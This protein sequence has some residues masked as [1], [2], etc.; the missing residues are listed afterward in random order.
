MA[1][2]STTATV[3]SKNVPP[4]SEA[5][6]SEASAT[7]DASPSSDAASTITADEKR[8][9]PSSTARTVVNSKGQLKELTFRNGSK[10]AQRRGS[11]SYADTKGFL[12]LAGTAIATTRTESAA[13]SDAQS[14]SRRG[15]SKAPS[16]SMPPGP[17]T[18][19]EGGTATAVSIIESA[20]ETSVDDAPVPKPSK[21]GIGKATGWSAALSSGRRKSLPGTVVETRS[22][23]TQRYA[24]VRPSQHQSSMKGGNK[25]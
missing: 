1:E 10:P 23:G 19:T 14:R 3:D 8:T 22:H 6:A 18:A 4:P 25:I 16:L 17:S 21:L 7:D 5:P 12:G 9:S 13:L 20:K 2:E 11:A 15:H 24:A